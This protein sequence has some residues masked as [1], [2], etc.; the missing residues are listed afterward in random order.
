MTV[1]LNTEI[2]SD[3]FL[4]NLG[5]FCLTP[6]RA[7]CGGK[8]YYHVDQVFLAKEPKQKSHIIVKITKIFIAIIFFLPGLILGVLFK[9]VSHIFSS[10]RQTTKDF[11]LANSKIELSR[12]IVEGQTAQILMKGEG[13]AFDP[14]IDSFKRGVPY[15]W[16][17]ANISSPKKMDLKSFKPHVVERLFSTGQDFNALIELDISNTSVVDEQIVKIIKRCPNLRILKAEGVKMSKA[18]YDLIVIN[19]QTLNKELSSFFPC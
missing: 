5:N 3:S 15:Q 14:S 12:Y 17:E 1:F 19:C 10:V 16:L 18:T 6:V 13:S 8:T 7:V 11:N 9:S 2:K 4:E